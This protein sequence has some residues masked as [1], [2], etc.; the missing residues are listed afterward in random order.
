M[1]P[2]VQAWAGEGEHVR[3]WRQ[4]FPPVL[5]EQPGLGVGVGGQGMLGGAL[6]TGCPAGR[7]AIAW[8]WGRRGC[9]RRGREAPSVWCL[10][11]GGGGGGG[12]TLCVGSARWDR[13]ASRF[14]AITRRICYRGLINEACGSAD[15]LVHCVNW[16]AG[17]RESQ[18]RDSRVR[19][20]VQLSLLQPGED[21]LTS[22]AITSGEGRG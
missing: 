6:W 5:P 18:R 4:A 21:R 9:E 13:A 11:G 2:H 8:P 22:W 10:R 19:I 20:G 16:T 14:P 1:R 12:G 17:E 15:W 3:T 7:Q